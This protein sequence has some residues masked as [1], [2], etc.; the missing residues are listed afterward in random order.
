MSNLKKVHCVFLH[1]LTRKQKK[2]LTKEKNFFQSFSFFL[3]I[4]DQLSWFLNVIKVM[5]ISNMVSN[6]IYSLDGKFD[7]FIP[8]QFE[9]D[10]AAAPYAHIN[11][12]EKLV[13]I[14]LDFS[15]YFTFFKIK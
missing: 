4:G 15:T 8:S 10:Y 5:S 9:N 12:L 1:I 2:M 11:L 14:H 7:F 3:R 13:K 6:Y